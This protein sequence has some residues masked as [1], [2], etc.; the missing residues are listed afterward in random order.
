MRAC[1]PDERE[2]T[3]S[4]IK[5]IWGNTGKDYLGLKNGRKWC[6]REFKRPDPLVKFQ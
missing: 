4:P 5:S 3:V 2:D 6:R 1:L